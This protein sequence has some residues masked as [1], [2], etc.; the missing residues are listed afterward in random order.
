[1]SDIW[2]TSDT[3]FAHSKNFLWK[4]RG[5]NSIEEH[6]SYI[7]ANWNSIVKSDDIVYHFGDVMLGNDL[8]YGMSCL[9]QLNGQIKIIRGNH[10]TDRRWAAYST[11]DNV[12]TL[13]YADIIKCGKWHFYLSHYPTYIGNMKESHPKFWN[14]CGHRH[15]K[16]KWEDIDKGQIYHVELDCHNNYPVNLETIKEDIRDLWIFNNS[17][18]EKYE[19]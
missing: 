2:F 14:L 19:I 7:I 8:S 18:K 5:F 11:L 1:M 6:D 9:N 12:E 13:G 15:C 3:H 16:N 17:I 10:D 4:P